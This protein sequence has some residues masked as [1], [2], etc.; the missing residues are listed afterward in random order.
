[1][2]FE[3]KVKVHIEF[4]EARADFEG[5][6]D[7]VFTMIVRFFT[8]VYPD[9]EILRKIIYT[10]DLTRLVEKI[11]GLVEI[12]PEG[13]IILIRRDLS[14]GNLICLALLASSIRNK[15]GSLAKGTLS[16][17]DLTMITGKAKKT[18][19]NELP[20][21]VAKGLFERTSEGEYL[22]TTLGIKRTEDIIDKYK[23]EMKS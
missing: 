2:S 14:A 16:S 10:P 8:Q 4:G 19:S 5:D 17:N 11:A 13:Q 12:T 15:L 3:G 22:I 21:L 20:Q 1:M 18:V 9:L 6:A 7:Q 23:A